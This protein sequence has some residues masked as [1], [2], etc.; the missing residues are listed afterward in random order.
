MLSSG[1]RRVYALA[2]TVSAS[3]SVS[4]ALPAERI[5]GQILKVDSAIMFEARLLEHVT[6]WL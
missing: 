2:P 5:D 1:M 4:L 6:F 3:R